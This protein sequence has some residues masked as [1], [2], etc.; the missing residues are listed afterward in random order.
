MTMTSESSGL[1]LE[2]AFNA[3]PTEMAPTAVGPFK[4]AKRSGIMSPINAPSSIASVDAIAA[5]GLST[6]PF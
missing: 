4:L 3:T 5:A 6:L 1:K 2:I